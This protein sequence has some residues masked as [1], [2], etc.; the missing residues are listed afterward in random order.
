MEDVILGINQGDYIYYIDQST[1]NDSR[2]WWFQGGTPTGGTAFAPSV[3]YLGI[4]ESGYDTKLTAS[5][6]GVERTKY[7][8]GIIVVYP[9]NFSINFTASPD[10][11]I[12]SQ[13]IQYSATGS[14]GSGVSSYLWSN[15]PGIGST[16]GTLLSTINYTADGWYE[17]T[18]TYLG[19][20][21]SSFVG[22]PQLSAYSDAGNFVTTSRSVTYRKLGPE[23]SINYAD[24]GIYATSG[25]YYD[26]QIMS[27]NTSLIPQLGGSNI[28][29][30]ID[31]SSYSP[32]WDN[33]YFHS[34][35]EIV[36]F[37]P[38]NYDLNLD[39]HKFAIILNGNI[40]DQL[41]VAEGYPMKISSN[42]ID[43]GNYIKPGFVSSDM[44]DSFIFTDYVTSGSGNTISNI[45]SFIGTG[46][47]DWSNAAIVDYMENYYYFSGSSKYIENYGYTSNKQPIADLASVLAFDGNVS[48][49]NWSGTGGTPPATMHGVC[50]PSSYF[51]D[52]FYSYAG[53]VDVDIVIS[54]EDGSV[55]DSF[56]VVLSQS[57][58]AGN[59]YDGNLI[60]SQDTA[61]NTN[62]GIASIINSGIALQGYSSNIFLDSQ[63]YYSPYE[64]GGNQTNPKYDKNLFHGLKV[65]VID[66]DLGGDFIH[67]VYISWGSGYL[68]ILDYLNGIIPSS[69]LTA[70]SRP[71]AGDIG[72]KRPKSWTGLTNP[73]TRPRT[74]TYFKGFKIGGQ[75]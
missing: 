58:D 48:G 34:T 31:Q 59:S 20:P 67:N 5:L 75:L 56:N 53:I 33:L 69:D 73:I 46:N 36:Y 52:N 61:Y 4:S 65:C 24:T 44:Y 62:N 19:S 39:F 64:N 8:E 68:A 7:R 28:M 10:N 6:N 42:E 17:I 41:A 18:G 51:F 66:P 27:I 74:G 1:G 54:T 63:P 16:S 32:K 47:R 21:N 15:I 71:F 37:Y 13:S 12:M 22:N 60:L 9:E 72:I 38:N 49:Y 2:D 70:L 30:R 45:S 57:G 3:R 50:V 29:I 14:T 25:L 43:L 11:L 55:I 23:E 35:S 26:P 40:L